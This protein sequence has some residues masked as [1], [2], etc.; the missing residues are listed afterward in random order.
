MSKETERVVTHEIRGNEVGYMRFKR[1][2]IKY[3]DGDLFYSG[4]IQDFGDA[5]TGPTFFEQ[6]Y[7]DYKL[8]R[9]KVS[10]REKYW[11]QVT[12]TQQ[13]VTLRS[14]TAEDLDELIDLNFQNYF[15][16]GYNRISAYQGLNHKIDDAHETLVFTVDNAILG[17]LYIDWE[18]RASLGEAYFDN[19]FCAPSVRNHG[20]GGALIAAGL[21]QATEGGFKTVAGQIT[22]DEEHC[23][24]VARLL[25]RN[26]FEVTN[27]TKYTPSWVVAD[28]AKTL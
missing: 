17:F 23:E 22:G 9:E 21:K 27:C 20:V 8:D 19:L 7:A 25:D 12:I 5:R 16:G 24:N 6:N 28:M 18:G 11:Q 2:D 14:A 13:N 10:R 26:G 1:V 3:S 4:W 15:D